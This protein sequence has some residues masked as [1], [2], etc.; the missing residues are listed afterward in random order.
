MILTW[1]TNLTG[2]TLQS[3]T[4]LVAA[5]VWSGVQPAPVVV[6]TNNSVTNGVSGARK[7]YRLI[8]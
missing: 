4:N 8:H 7:F 5:P 6:N 3:T 1:P 2:F